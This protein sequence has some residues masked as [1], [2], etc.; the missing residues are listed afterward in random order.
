MKTAALLLAL[1]CTGSTGFAQQAKPAAWHAEVAAQLTDA[2][3]QYA[4]VKAARMIVTG[5]LAAAAA[6]PRPARRRR[7]PLLLPRHDRV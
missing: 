5:Q 7:L 1:L 3:Q 6:G 4:Y 2:E